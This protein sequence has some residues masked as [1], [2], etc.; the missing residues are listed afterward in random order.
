MLGLVR[1]FVWAGA[2][3]VTVA[4]PAAIRIAAAART[5]R[6]PLAVKHSLRL[7]LHWML[8]PSPLVGKPA[9]G[10]QREKYQDTRFCSR[11]VAKQRTA[12]PS[13]GI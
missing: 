2:V 5:Q 12:A 8:H 13:D 7:H 3:T 11:S 9:I 10:E 6:I 4:A 1:V